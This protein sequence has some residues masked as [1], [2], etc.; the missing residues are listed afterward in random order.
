MVITLSDTPWALE[1]SVLEYVFEHTARLEAVAGRLRSA[2]TSGRP[3]PGIA[4]LPIAGLLFPRGTPLSAALGAT[5]L[6]T[7]GHE[8]RRLA[9]DESVGS[10]V[11]NMDTPG[12]MVEGVTEFAAEVRR[13]RAQKPVLAVANF[14][15]ASAGYWIGASATEVVASPSSQ[16]GGIGIF[17]MHD[18]LSKALEAEGVTRTIVSAG[19]HKVEGN[20]LG[21]LTD[22]ARVT[23]Q[24]QVDDAFDRFVADVATGRGVSVSAVRGGFGE[25]RTLSAPRALAAGMV[26]RVATLDETIARLI[27]QPVRMSLSGRAG[28]ARRSRKVALALAGIHPVESAKTRR[29]RAAQ[30]ALLGCAS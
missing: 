5:S 14:L 17:A 20:P 7:T 13:A 6:E 1:K 10:I 24:A 12:G 4:V 26:D 28:A 3:S 21:P 27:G 9:A 22:E 18:D 11:L 25:G 8:L 23:R 30:R 19:K 29:L 16:V 15:M 2:A